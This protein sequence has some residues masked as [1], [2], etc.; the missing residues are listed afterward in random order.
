MMVLLVKMPVLETWPILAKIIVTGVLFF[1][2]FYTKR[3]AFEGR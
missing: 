3:Y 2:N 1:F